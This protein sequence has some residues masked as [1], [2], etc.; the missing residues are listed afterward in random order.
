MEDFDLGNVWARQ[1][2]LD[3]VKSIIGPLEYLPCYAPELFKF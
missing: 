3:L 2:K 1:T